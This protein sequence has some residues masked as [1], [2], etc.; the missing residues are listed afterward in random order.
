MTR[1]VLIYMCVCMCEV[2][3]EHTIGCRRDLS[4]PPCIFLPLCH[5]HVCGSQCLP[6][7]SS[8]SPRAFSNVTR[9]LSA[10]VYV[11]RE[12]GR[13]RKEPLYPQ[14]PFLS[15]HCLLCG[16]RDGLFVFPKHFP[17]TTVAECPTQLSD[18]SSRAQKCNC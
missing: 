13:R 9:V 15:L 3:L 10:G 5:L 2:P 17:S 1:W 12:Q 6:L 8:I 14:T 4:F 18:C 7:R 16:D 11:H